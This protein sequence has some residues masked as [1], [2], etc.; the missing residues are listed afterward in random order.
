MKRQGH[1][2][3]A[4]A[5]LWDDGVIDPADTRT[6]AWH[7]QSHRG[8][9]CRPVEESIF[10]VFQ[11]VTADDRFEKL[12][13]ND[14][15]SLT[16]DDKGLARV[17]LNRPEKH[18]AFDDVTDCQICTERISNSLAGNRTVHVS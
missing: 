8:T 6:G 1:P 16:I 10:G 12:F 18:N 4:S 14:R 7:C 5:R 3:Y 17:T 11:D 2:Y 13:M 9:Q 15:L